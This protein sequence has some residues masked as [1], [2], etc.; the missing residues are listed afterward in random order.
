MIDKF[1]PAESEQEFKERMKKRRLHVECTIFTKIP[2][3]DKPMQ[4]TL[5]YP[6]NVFKDYDTFR[7]AIID[8]ID[9][10]YLWGYDFD[11]LNKTTA[12]TCGG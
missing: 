9:E 2:D 3:Y 6:I 8:A 4:I 11:R 10:N 12:S 5:I 7:Q 1:K